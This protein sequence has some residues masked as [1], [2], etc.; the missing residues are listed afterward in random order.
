MR[1]QL[2]E[3]ARSVSSLAEGRRERLRAVTIVCADPGEAEL[4]RTLLQHML[5]R[6]G[7]ARVDVLS[8]L[9][10]GPVRVLSL[11]FDPTPEQH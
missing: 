6:R 3:L 8:V 5:T 4:A 9:A 11:E 7:L 2:S 10:D 1:E